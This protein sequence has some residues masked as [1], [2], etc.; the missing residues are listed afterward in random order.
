MKS[1]NRNN[2]QDYPLNPIISAGIPYTLV[3]RIEAIEFPTFGLH[4]PGPGKKVAP[5]PSHLKNSL[6]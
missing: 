2:P 1:G 6:N 4:E 5:R 3:L